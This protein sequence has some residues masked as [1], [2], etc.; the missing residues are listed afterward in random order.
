MKTRPVIII[1]TDEH[2]VN[3][4]ACAAIEAIADAHGLYKLGG[5]LFEVLA[6]CHHPRRVPLAFLRHLLSLA[7]D[8]RRLTPSGALVTA[9]VPAWCVRAVSARGDWNVPTYRF[10]CKRAPRGPHLAAVRGG[11]A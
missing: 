5:K 10:G 2:R 9:H 7:A 1:G 3:D 11:A 4:A 8:W 6:D